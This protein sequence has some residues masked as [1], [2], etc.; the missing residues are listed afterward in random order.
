ME[1]AP[2]APS[3]SAA[4]SPVR[5]PAAAA[6]VV[7]A[8]REGPRA[9]AARLARLCQGGKGG[10]LERLLDMVRVC[11]RDGVPAWAR[12]ISLSLLSLFYVSS[13]LRL[14]PSLSFRSRFC[15]RVLLSALAQK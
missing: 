14:S 13:S 7:Q 8:L 9:A 3:I 1:P 10:V 6:E 2:P 5:A 4:G 11:G 15:S 12:M